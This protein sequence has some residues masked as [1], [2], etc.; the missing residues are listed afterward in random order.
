MNKPNQ[1]NSAFTLIELL[2]VI[3][4]IAILAGMLLPALAKAKQKAAKIKCTN[5]L[6]QI[7]LGFRTWASDK[8]DSYPW[9]F[10]QRYTMRFVDPNNPWGGGRSAGYDFNRHGTANS[11]APRTWTVY[12][13]MSNSIVNPKILLCP[14]NRTKRNAVSHEYSTNLQGFYSTAISAN[15]HHPLTWREDPNYGRGAG[16]D[17]SISYGIMRWNRG[18]LRRGVKQAN[19]PDQILA[20]DFNVNRW[21]GHYN[22]FPRFDP[23]PGG[24]GHTSG[25]G[26]RLEQRNVTESH[27]P[28][29]RNI[30]V[31]VWGWVHG[32][33]E[34]NRFNLHGDSGNMAM[35]DGAVLSLVTEQ[36]DAL[37]RAMHQG[38]RG[39]RNAAGNARGGF[40][41]WIWQP[42]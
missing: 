39:P 20:Y 41:T 31:H 10:E 35:S 7:A 13:L 28:S 24:M 9:E 30:S 27:A 12:A 17:N 25:D 34:G 22:E 5:N 1:S 38:A 16:Y 29:S 8:D 3:A 40:N 19:S 14:G 32:F 42:W 26:N 21:H 33:D 18:E 15:G 37:G 4:I 6:R 23:I 2:V 11:E 36:I